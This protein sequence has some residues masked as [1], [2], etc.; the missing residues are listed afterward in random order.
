MRFDKRLA[1]FA[2]L[3]ALLA[4]GCGGSSPYS[5][6][7]A[8]SGV[9]AGKAPR[10]AVLVIHGGAWHIVGMRAVRAMRNDAARL[11]ALGF[12]TLNIDYRRGRDS[13]PDV[14]AAYDRLRGEVGAQTP[15]CAF[16]TSAGGH[17]ALMLAERRP[18]V[19]C[20][21]AEA[22]PTL[23]TSLTGR[24]LGYA[25]HYFGDDA[26]LRAWSPVLGVRRLRA[27]T[28]VAQ[29]TDDPTVPFAQSTALVRADPS[30]RRVVLRPGPWPWVHAN[31][32]G[33]DLERLHADEAAFI[34][35]SAMSAREQIAGMPVRSG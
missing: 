16:G 20:V 30:V 34:E 31:V 17:L 10:G 23:L 27:A 32:D 33:G 18:D 28:L 6:R 3:C 21:V 9:F 4:V 1:T 14:L 26:E 29:A 8:P 35:Q 13:L 2:A 12:E 25:R 22:P 19:A 11:N 24:V 15:I 5:E 7:G